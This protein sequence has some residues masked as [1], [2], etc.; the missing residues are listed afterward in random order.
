MGLR[1]SSR[2]L[3]PNYVVENIEHTLKM[4]TIFKEFVRLRPF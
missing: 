1:S 3:L 4:R 2:I